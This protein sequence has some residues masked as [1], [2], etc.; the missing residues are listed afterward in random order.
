MEDLKEIRNQIN[1]IDEEIINLLKKRFD[2][3]KKVRAYKISHNKKIYDPK[4]E[5]EILKKI[6]EES[7]EYGEY[8][9]LIFQEIM[10]QSKNLQKEEEKYGLLGK[11]LGHSYSKIIHE[12]IAFY[13]Y[14]YFEKNEEELDYFFE[15]KAYLNG[16]FKVKFLELFLLFLIYLIDL[17]HKFLLLLV[18]VLSF[19]FLFFQ[20]Y[21]C[22]NHL[23][24]IYFF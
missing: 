18:H 8:F 24:K 4:R 20:K 2:L 5:R 11:S 15:R 12:K 23:P 7:P 19:S 14:Q 9:L 10:D 22:M 21:L 17:L 3:S 13:D 16:G 1:K 6:K